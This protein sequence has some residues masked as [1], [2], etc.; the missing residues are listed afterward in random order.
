[1]KRR[2]VLSVALASLEARTV[3]KLTTKTT[4]RARVV[5]ETEWARF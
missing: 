2:L 1:M 5:E 3:A 4:K